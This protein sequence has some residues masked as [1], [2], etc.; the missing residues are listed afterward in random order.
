MLEEVFGHAVVK[1]THQWGRTLL[2]P[3]P[4]VLIPTTHGRIL[5]LAGEDLILFS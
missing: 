4:A 5:D 1:M 3:V 2:C